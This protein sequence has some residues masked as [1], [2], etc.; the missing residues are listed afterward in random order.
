MLVG[1]GAAYALGSIPTG[2]W[3]A[4]V[5]K[6]IDVRQFGSGNIGASN[7]GRVLGKP[8]GIAVLVFDIGKG[9][10]AVVLGQRF[11]YDPAGAPLSADA[12]KILCGAAAICGHNWTVFLRFRGGKGVAT[13][14]GVLLALSPVLL[15]SSAAIWGVAAKVSG[16]VSVASIASGIGFC[17]L[18][19]ALS[20]SWEL[21]VFGLVMA[22]ILIFKHRGNLQ[23]LAQGTEPKIGKG[24]PGKVN[25]ALR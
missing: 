8:W 22:A 1:W 12:Y 11:F 19:F 23:R 4:K 16:Y 25:D 21:K 5:R 10:L 7:V 20:T 13:S 18:T 15:L 3:L 17:V 2:Y 24:G 6:G 14:A 9:V